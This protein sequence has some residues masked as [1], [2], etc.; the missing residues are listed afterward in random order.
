MRGTLADAEIARPRAGDIGAAANRISVP[1]SGNSQECTAS[2]AVISLQCCVQALDAAGMALGGL[3][4]GPVTNHAM[5]LPLAIATVSGRGW[6]AKCRGYSTFSLRTVPAQAPTLISA[7]LVWFSTFV[8]VDLLMPGA[9][10]AQTRAIFAAA[11][12]GLILLTGLR[13]VVATLLRSWH[14]NG[15]LDCNV[16]VVGV[17]DVSRSFMD[18]VRNGPPS[19][20]RIFGAYR[21]SAGETQVTHAGVLIRGDIDM[22]IEHSCKKMFDLIVLALP[23][24][25]EEGTPKIRERL[26][27]CSC[28][29]SVLTDV[30]SPWWT[31]SYLEQLDCGWTLAVAPRPYTGWQAL[32]KVVLDRSLAAMLL[33]LLAPLLLVIALAIRCDTPGP[34]LFRQKR[35]GINKKPFMILKFRTMYHHLRDP[36]AE[37]QTAQND[38]RVTPL[39]RWLRRFSLDELPQLANVL[40]GD[41][42]LVGPRPHAVGTKAGHRDLDEV[43][44]VYA[45]RLRVKPGITG[46]AQI[47]GCRGALESEEHIRRRVEYD[48]Y[49]IRHW[50]LMLDLKILLLTAVREVCRPSVY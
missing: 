31:N 6:I 2:S 28:N 37:R 7:A 33:M 26:A 10:Q 40:V 19:H 39:G 50:S 18:G 36:L 43:A 32:Q 49:Y 34:V 21:T 25:N 48:L 44:A 23:R 13:V 29:V 11:A 15:R 12:T 46:W 1:G 8:A 14:N 47:N 27:G 3:I 24:G 30:E 35:L 22:L 42:S 20:I 9:D 5:L 17:N 45:A 4:A 38:P 41:M 16:A